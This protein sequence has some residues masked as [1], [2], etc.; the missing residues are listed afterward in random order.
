MQA[1]PSTRPGRRPR[2]RLVLVGVAAV[3]V[4]TVVVLALAPWKPVS[5]RQ[6]GQTPA[7]LSV[8]ASQIATDL[9]GSTYL[10]DI[11]TRSRIAT[12]TASGSTGVDWVAFSPDGKVLA[13]ADRNG[14]T[15]LW[16]LRQH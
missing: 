6:A 9:N 5:G 16:A 13:T 11:A 8:T 1:D 2:I 7:R 14:R 10:W 4:I 3:A 12:L 15:Y